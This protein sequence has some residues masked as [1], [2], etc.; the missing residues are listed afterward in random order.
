[1]DSKESK[2]VN[3]KG[4]QPWIFTGRTDAEA[5]VFWPPDAKNQLTGKDPDAGKDWGP[6]KKATTEDEMFGWHHW[7]KGHEFLQ[8]LGDSE[9]QRSLACCSPQGCK[10]LDTTEWLNTNN[11]EEKTVVGPPSFPGGKF[12]QVLSFSERREGLSLFL[13][14][15]CCW[16]LATQSCRTLCDPL[17][18]SLPD[19][20]IHGFPSQEY[21]SGL[22]VPPP[23]GMLGPSY[24]WAYEPTCR[25]PCP[26]TV[27]HNSM[28]PL[29]GTH[30]PPLQGK[31]PEKRGKEQ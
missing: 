12:F 15:P 1:M 10:E 26:H 14:E 8:A 5:P 3:L 30:V 25:S 18:W 6:E 16:G 2:P 4:N 24:S 7:L 22:P 9:G 17:D 31:Q 20:S 27:T 29:S 19:S 23:L 13:W 28:E 11:N 21:W